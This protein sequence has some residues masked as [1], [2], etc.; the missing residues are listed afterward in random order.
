[1]SFTEEARIPIL[2]RRNINE[3]NLG[4]WMRKYKPDAVISSGR[5]YSML[6]ELGYRVPDDVGFASLDLSEA[7]SEIAGLD[8][9]Y[10]LV[11]REVAKLV[12]QDVSFNTVGS[13]KFPKVVLVDSHFRKGPSLVKVGNAVDIGLRE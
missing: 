4:A 5:I 2:P 13:P 1:M 12:M 8:Q 11:G 10:D 9:R 3:E 7:P 6:R